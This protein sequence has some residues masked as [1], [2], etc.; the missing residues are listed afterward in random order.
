MGCQQDFGPLQGSNTHVLTDVV[1][2]ASEYTHPPFIGRAKNRVLGT[3]RH[4]FVYKGMQFPVPLTFT[5]G[6]SDYI[7][8]VYSLV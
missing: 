4:E 6:H 8:I 7:G 3:R 2:V 5:A 1:V